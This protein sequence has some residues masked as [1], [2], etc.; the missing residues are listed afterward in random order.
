MIANEKRQSMEDTLAALVDRNDVVDTI[1]QLFLATDR[2]DWPTV[3]SCFAERVTFDMTSL[4]GGEP[5]VLTPSQIASAWD[6]GLAPIEHVH[7]Q[8]GN[9]Q[10][11]VNGDEAEASC[12]GIAFHYRRVASGNNTRTFVGSYDFELRRRDDGWRI[13]LFRFNARYVEGN[14]A[15]ESDG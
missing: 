7:H 11:E 6:Q 13:G 8:A 5:V 15:L 3:E 4:A 10:V 9:F 12:Y 2:R 14:L 1:V